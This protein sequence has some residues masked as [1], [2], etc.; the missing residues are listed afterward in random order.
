MSATDQK[1]LD[2]LYWR[3]IRREAFTVCE[4]LHGALLARWTDYAHERGYSPSWP[5]DL[6]FPADV[7]F[8]WAMI[9]RGIPGAE[10][11]LKY[12]AQHGRI[13]LFFKDR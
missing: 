12:L 2:Q 13:C 8:L 11:L 1:M 10:Q 7:G 5:P 4:P 3:P 9:E 6:R